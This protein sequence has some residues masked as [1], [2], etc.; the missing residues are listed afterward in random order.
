MFIPIASGNIGIKNMINSDQLDENLKP[1]SA[2]YFDVG[3]N[4]TMI[5]VVPSW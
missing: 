5:G 4:V 2:K 1:K 3:A